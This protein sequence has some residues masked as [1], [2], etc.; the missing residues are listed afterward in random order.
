MLDISEHEVFTSLNSIGDWVRWTTSQ[1]YHHGVY[2][3][4][5]TDNAWDEALQSVMHILHLPVESDAIVFHANL[6]VS[7]KKGVLQ[8]VKERINTRKP[9]PYLTNVAW[10]MGMHF[11]VD[12]RVLIPRSLIAEFIERQ[13][14][15]WVTDPDAQ[16][17]I[18]DMCTGSGCLA[19]GCAMTFPY[20]TIDA[21]DKFDTALEVATQNITHYDLQRRINLIQ[22][23]LF[24]ELGDA[25]YDVI[26]SNPPYVSSS[27]MEGLPPEYNHEPVCALEADDNGL[28]IVDRILASAASHLND[29]GILI[30]EV[31]NA[32]ESVCEKYPDLPFVWLTPERGEYGIF[33][34]TKEQ[35][36]NQEERANV[37]E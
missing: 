14:S 2:F 29:D 8:I 1:Y 33:L 4:H 10:F 34:I 13:L 9:L 32:H 31:G 23:D 26:L 5:G 21:V 36:V 15:P 3:G 22:S 12:E 17:N 35:L 7:E 6:T 25:T 18:L 20:S 28:S 19:I 24:N 30:V 37:G 27:E 11:F 16:L